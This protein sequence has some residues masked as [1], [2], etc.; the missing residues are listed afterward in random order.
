MQTIS[1][2][3]LPAFLEKYQ[4]FQFLEILSAAKLRKKLPLKIPRKERKIFFAS[5]LNHIYFDA[6]QRTKVRALKQS[7]FPPITLSLS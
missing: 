1:S 3:S 2:I 6:E 4:N 5:L 7:L